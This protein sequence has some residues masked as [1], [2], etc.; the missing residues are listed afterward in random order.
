MTQDSAIPFN[1]I[2]RAD[3][4]V[5]DEAWI[6]AFLHR[7]PYG[8]LATASEGQPFVNTNLFAYDETAQVIYLHTA[9]QGR[10]RSN[11][12]ANG[13]VC[14]SV[15][16]MGRLLPADTA[17][18]FSVEYASVVVFGQASI[19]E[20]MEQARHALQ[21]LLD[22]YAPHLRPGSDYRPITD[23]E[24]EITSVYRIQIDSWSGKKKEAPADFPGAYFYSGETTFRRES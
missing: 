16:E 23:E 7:A 13:R 4:A 22:K 8:I 14:F 11:V 5:T 6:R 17:M 3:R 1:R 9:R 12:E 24:I 15:G 2:L 18:G 10:T 19:I 20:D 21:L